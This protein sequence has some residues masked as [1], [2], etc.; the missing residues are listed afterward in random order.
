MKW[1]REDRGQDSFEYLLTIGLIA[2]PFA[3]LLVAAF[4]LIVPQALSFICDGI[5][6]LGGGSC[7][8]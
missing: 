1:L 4:E 5:D 3:L 8:G 6:P 2:V 7:F